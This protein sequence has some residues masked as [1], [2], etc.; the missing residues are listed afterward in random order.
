MKCS[1]IMQLPPSDVANDWLK[2]TVHCGKHLYFVGVVGNPEPDL[3]LECEPGSCTSD[4]L[5]RA[6]EAIG[7]R[8]VFSFDFSMIE[9]KPDTA[10]KLRSIVENAIW[11][12]TSNNPQP[13][14]HP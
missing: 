3:I 10:K 1:I 5:S 8:P 13:K 7:I 6:L 12:T 2:T 14:V 11:A 9:V 4:N